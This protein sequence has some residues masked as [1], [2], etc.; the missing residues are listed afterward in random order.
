MEKKEVINVK[1]LALW[2]KKVPQM[3]FYLSNRTPFLSPWNMLWY[4]IGGKKKGSTSI[5]TGLAETFSKPE[6]NFRMFNARN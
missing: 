6:C 3:V 2:Q 1:L 4:F 5:Q